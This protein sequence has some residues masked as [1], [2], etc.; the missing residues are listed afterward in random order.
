[1]EEAVR[2]GLYAKAGEPLTLKAVAIHVS[3]QG[4]AARVTVA[5][6]Y[7]N[8]ED[9]PDPWLGRG[10]PGHAFSVVWEGR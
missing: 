6:K 9:G 10:G 5:Q 1:M 4:S 8:E 3:G 7:R 2:V